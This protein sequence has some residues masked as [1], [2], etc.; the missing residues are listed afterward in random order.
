VAESLGVTSSAELVNRSHGARVTLFGHVAALKETATKSGNRMA[1]LTLEDMAGTVEVTV[2]PEPYKAAA[3]YLRAR[4]PVVVRGRVDD[5]DKGRVVLAEDVRLLE[6]SL[7][8][9]GGRPRNGGEPS[10]C[11]VRVRAGEDSAERLAALR[12]LCEEHPGGVPV[13]LHVLLPTTEVVIRARG[14]SV[15]AGR[16]LVARLEELLGPGATVI[17]HAGRA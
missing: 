7:A 2:F 6:Q 16:D 17:D 4:E 11:R 10:A 13:F 9:G 3:P 1:F 15:D 12:R 14:V 8:A 5:G